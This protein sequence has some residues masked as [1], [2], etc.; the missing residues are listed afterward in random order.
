[1]FFA[2]EINQSS[3]IN[4]KRE[5]YERVRFIRILDKY[6]LYEYYLANRV[7]KTRHKKTNDEIPLLPE[8]SL[9]SQ[10]V[11]LDDISNK[12]PYK[13]SELNTSIT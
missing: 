5:T 10:S 9:R 2:A 7:L 8:G 6:E 13:P 1:M 3:I 4:M 11:E 12:N